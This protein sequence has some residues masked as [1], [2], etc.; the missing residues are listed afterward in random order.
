MTLNFLHLLIFVQ[1]EHITSYTIPNR[2]VNLIMYSYLS[3]RGDVL[4]FKA[5]I[6][7]AKTAFFNDKTAMSLVSVIGR[8]AEIQMS[9]GMRFPTMWHFDKCRLGRALQ[10]PVKLRNSKWCSVNSLTIIEYSN[11]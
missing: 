9:R 11:D 5:R 7:P 1:S 2:Y 3:V 8:F 10:P 4:Q 6:I